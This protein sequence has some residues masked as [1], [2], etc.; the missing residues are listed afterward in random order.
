MDSKANGSQCCYFVRQ[1]IDTNDNVPEFTSLIYEATIQEEVQPGQKVVKVSATDL[2]SPKIQDPLAYSIDKTGL[3]YFSIDSKTGQITTANEKLDREKD[4]MVSFYVFAYDG[5]HRGEALVRVNLTDIN[6]NAPYFPSPPY[7]GYVEENKNPGASVMVLQAVDLDSGVNAEIFYELKDNANGK[8]KI[9]PNS[10]LVTTLETLERESSENEFTIRVKATNRQAGGNPPLSGTVTATIKVADGNDQSPAFD[11]LVYKANVPEDALPGYFVTKVS[12]TDKDEGPN[13][14][15]EYTITAGNDPY[16]FY[17]DPRTGRFLVSGLLDFDKGKKTYN[18]TVMVSD[19]GNPPRSAPRPAL[20]YINVLDANDNPP[21]FVPAEYNKR[22][23]ESVKPGDTV[24]L[25]TAVDKDTGTNAKF[26][27]SITDGDNA[28]MFAIRSNTNNGSIG[29]IYTFLQ[30]DRETVPR[31]NLTI[32]ATDSGGLQGIAVV[33]LI[34]TDTND[35]GPWFKPRYFEGTVKAGI[36]P[37]QGQA[38]VT[39]RAY[40]PDEASNGPPFTFSVV[41]ADLRSRFKL[42]KATDLTADMVAF[43]EFNREVKQ[44][45]EVKVRAVDSG[46]PSQDNTTGF[47][48]IEVKDDGNRNEPFD[49]ELTIIVNAYNGRF[50]GGIIGKAYYKDDDYEGDQNEY[51]MTTQNYFT[52]NSANGNIT[53][54]ANIPLGT[55]TFSVQVEE[56]KQRSGNFRKAVTSDVTVIVQSVTNEAIQQSVAV[57]ILEMRKTSFF[58]GDYFTNCRGVLANILTGGVTDRILIFTIQKSPVNRVPLSNLFGVE[59]HLAALLGG[60]GFMNRMEVVRL[61]LQ[62][63]TSLEELGKLNQSK[64]GA[65]CHFSHS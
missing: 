27:F 34:I 53:A 64:S 57:Q 11:P 35:N 26:K 1:V 28:N 55:Y 14:E 7:V 58:V 56:Q 10:G 21:I 20:V 22:V 36:N 12:A 17:I 45:W 62:N 47:V 51:T 38:V 4:Q 8:F 15:L 60:G 46:S 6:D 41:D 18:L 63:K 19:R 29:E 39:L 25:V 59:I 50:A 2:D 42:T 31:Y 44:N 54:E 49:G 43:G 16:Q 24:L 52:L 23:S 40:D 65:K 61:L 5:K 9:D 30:L 3:T 37:T 33:R 13:A 32:T 48:Y